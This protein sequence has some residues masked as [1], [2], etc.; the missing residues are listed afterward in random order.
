MMNPET[1]AAVKRRMARISGQVAGLQRMIDEDR[2]CIDVLTQIAA[3]RSALAKVG[4]QLLASH[5][6]TCVRSAFEGDDPADR[7][8]KMDELLAVFGKYGGK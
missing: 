6:E 3:A 2:Y 1:K 7:Q 4:Q 5:L 8:A